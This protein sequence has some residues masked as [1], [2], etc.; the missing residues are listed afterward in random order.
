VSQRRQQ[1]PFPERKTFRF[2][3][4]VDTVTTVIDEL[5]S[6]K[7]GAEESFDSL[8]S[9]LLDTTYSVLEA[10]LPYCAESYEIIN[11]A[12]LHLNPGG[13]IRIS[14]HTRSDQELAYVFIRLKREHPECKMSFQ[15]DNKEMLIIGKSF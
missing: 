8:G 5:M 9:Q 13:E 14:G 6:E 4:D 10:D 7:A 2:S 15:R 12:L 11:T 1:I 3:S